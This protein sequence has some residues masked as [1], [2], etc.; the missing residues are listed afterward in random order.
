VTVCPVSSGSQ[1]RVGGG[2]LTSA[3]YLRLTPSV[4]FVTGA[5]SGLGVCAFEPVLEGTSITVVPLFNNRLG[6]VLL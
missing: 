3:C 4:T 2:A 1:V 6:I 5:D